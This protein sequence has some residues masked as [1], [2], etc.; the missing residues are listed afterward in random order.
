MHIRDSAFS[1][2]DSWNGLRKMRSL[3]SLPFCCHRANGSMR[4]HPVSKYRLE[5]FRP[6]V[7]PSYKDEMACYSSVIVTFLACPSGQI[8][9]LNILL[10]GDEVNYLFRYPLIQ[11]LIDM[12]PPN[13]MFDFFYDQNLFVVFV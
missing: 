10:D 11:L 3:S 5:P 7:H 2:S 4:V 8:F 6:S 1:F 12:G 13:V 9:E